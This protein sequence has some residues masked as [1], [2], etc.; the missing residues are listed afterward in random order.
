MRW[1]RKGKGIELRGEA[2][3][4]GKHPVR[5][6]KEKAHDKARLCGS[7]FLNGVPNS[8]VKTEGVRGRSAGATFLWDL[9]G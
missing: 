9:L 1:A 7:L 6:Q 4:V 8:R 3:A 5:V 2:Q